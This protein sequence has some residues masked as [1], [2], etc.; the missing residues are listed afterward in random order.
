MPARWP[1]ASESATERRLEERGGRMG[2]R[3]CPAGGPWRQLW[4]RQ[5]EREL[6]SERRDSHAL[7]T[8]RATAACNRRE[9]RGLATATGRRHSGRRRLVVAGRFSATR[10]GAEAKAQRKQGQKRRARRRH[11]AIR[12]VDRSSQ[13]IHYIIP[14]HRCPAAQTDTAT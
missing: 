4:S 2:R 13:L 9:R 5:R 3:R 11:R 1:A 10:L 12:P 14:A 7:W 8:A 6:W